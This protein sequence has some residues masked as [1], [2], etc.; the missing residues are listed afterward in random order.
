MKSTAD[1][2]L[3][4]GRLNRG[5]TLI[6]VMVVVVVIGVLAAIALPSYRS[7]IERS[8]RA[9][10]KATLLEAAQFMER[11]RSANFSYASVPSASPP[12]PP[13]LPTRLTVSPSDGTPR[14]TISLET[15]TASSFLLT[16]TPQGW[17]DALCGNLT[18]DN[19]GQ[20]GQSLGDAATCWNK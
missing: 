10:A 12:T 14:Y 7:Y 4:K 6:E 20:R 17:T 13:T 8:H 15:P 1:S 3:S 19:L 2:D 16:A 9:S 5:F 11:F 18:L